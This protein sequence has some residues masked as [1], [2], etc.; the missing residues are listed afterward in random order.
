MVPRSEDPPFP[1]G[2][3]GWNSGM[4]IRS[5]VLLGKMREVLP[6]HCMPD[7]LVLVKAFPM[8]AHGEG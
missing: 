4:R 3:E 1:S 7:V 2:G 5:R 6:A 8:T